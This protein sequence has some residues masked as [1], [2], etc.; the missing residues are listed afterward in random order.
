MNQNSQFKKYY[1]QILEAEEKARDS[2][3]ITLNEKYIHFYLI[4]FHND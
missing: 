3:A 4:L 1:D 2:V